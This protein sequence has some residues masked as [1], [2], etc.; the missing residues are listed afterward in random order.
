MTQVFSSSPILAHLF[1]HGRNSSLITFCFSGQESQAAGGGWSNVSPISG[2]LGHQAAGG[3]HVLGLRQALGFGRLRLGCAPRL[4]AAPGGRG[5]DAG[6]GGADER[7]GR[8][9][10]GEEFGDSFWGGRRGVLRFWT[11]SFLWGDGGGGGT[12]GSELEPRG[13]V[14]TPESRALGAFGFCFSG[15]RDDSFEHTTNGF[16]QVSLRQG[17]WGPVPVPQCGLGIFWVL[18]LGKRGIDSGCCSPMIYRK[19]SVSGTGMCSLFNH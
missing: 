7:P 14:R 17:S 19:C 16:N 10:D 15:F 6:H 11:P 12:G 8:G 2:L 18:A 5:G 1:G 9:S 13:W 3:Q 4:G